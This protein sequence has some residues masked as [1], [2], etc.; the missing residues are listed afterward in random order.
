LNN[1]EI[2]NVQDL[3]EL[4]VSYILSFFMYKNPVFHK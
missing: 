2:E 1:E 4:Y 3:H